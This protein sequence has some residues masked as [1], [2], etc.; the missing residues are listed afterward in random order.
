MILRQSDATMDI[1]AVIDVEASGFGA[2][3]YPIE[4]GFVLA[5]GGRG[6]VLIRPEPGWTHWDA[7]AQ[8][9]HRLNRPLLHEQGRSVGEVAVWLNQHLAGL[10]IYSDAWAH[11]SSWLGLL[12]E[13]AGIMPR[14]RMEA[15]QVLLSEHQRQTWAQ[16]RDELM[17]QFRLVRHR[18][19]SDAWLIQQTY[20]RT[21]QIQ[22]ESLDQRQQFSG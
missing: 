10:T 3:S 4:V 5:D 19:S 9:L 18:A 8:A 7:G 16:A 15:L 17:Q 20:L 2:G 22:G 12:F 6:C 1:P 21:L 11:D 14:F 13:T